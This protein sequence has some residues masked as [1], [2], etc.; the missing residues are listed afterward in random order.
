MNK[1]YKKIII[2]IKIIIKKLLN[3]NLA[4]ANVQEK[5]LKKEEMV[6]NTIEI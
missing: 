3:I 5:K 1:F 4:F 2:I 6:K